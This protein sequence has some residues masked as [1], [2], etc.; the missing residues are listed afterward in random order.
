M[1]SVGLSCLVLLQMLMLLLIFT[2]DAVAADD[3]AHVGVA[4]VTLLLR[5]LLRL[6]TGNVPPHDILKS[7][8]MHIVQVSG[9]TI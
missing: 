3:D 5:L 7:Y 2:V 9:H 8:C 4:A 6:V 1:H